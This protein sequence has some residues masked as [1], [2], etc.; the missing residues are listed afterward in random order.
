VAR[1]DLR[2]LVSGNSEFAFDL[3]QAIREEEGNLFYSPYSIS[4]ALGMTYAGARHETERQM[5]ETLHYVLGQDDLH[6]AFNALELELAKRGEARGGEGEEAFRLEIANSIWGQKGYEFL[7]EFLD[8][9][10]EDYG[11]GLRLLDFASEAKQAR[12][13]INGWVS[14]QTEG[15]IENLIPPGLIDAL[16][17][18]VLV[19]AIYFNA[20]WADPFEEQQTRDGT[21]YLLD[22]EEVTVPMMKQGESLGYAEGD[23]YQAVELPYRGGEVSMVIVLPEAGEFEAFE[24]S[25]EAILVDGI[26]QTLER[27]TVNLVMPKFEFDSSFGLAKTLAKMGMPDAFSD[28]AD[29]SGMDGTR[30]LFIKE[31]V[32]KAYM[33][34]DEAGTEAAAAT[35]VVVAEMAAPMEPVEMVLDHPFIFMIR[36]IGTGAILFVGRVVDPSV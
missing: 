9:L 25:I 14:E 18:L 12:L 16:T 13:V 35:A 32:H 36:D 4:A 33:S 11:A 34:V 21:F 5:E 17:R 20:P 10:A 1:D 19:N 28:V 26:V 22:G 27:R 6:R 15:K 31:V 23:G 29:F 3:Y 30:N 24:A 8:T 7:A 2:E